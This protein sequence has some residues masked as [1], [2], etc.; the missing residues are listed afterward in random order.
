MKRV[1]LLIAL[2]SGAC[3]PTVPYEV[4][5]RGAPARITPD[6]PAERKLEYDLMVVMPAD[7]AWPRAEGDEVAASDRV[8]VIVDEVLRSRGVLPVHTDGADVRLVLIHGEARTELWVSRGT[9]RKT[10]WAPADP[11]RLAL[12]YV[13]DA[14]LRDF[15]PPVT[16]G[17]PAAP[18]PAPVSAATP[19]PRAR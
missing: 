4:R 7:Q 6:A 19:A 11:A 2:A 16:A 18:A 17:Q 3:A 15:L 9:D 12:E 14:M 13:L 5:L 10:Y 1:A 8:A